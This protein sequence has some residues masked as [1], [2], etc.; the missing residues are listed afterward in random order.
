MKIR[1]LGQNLKVSA[2][3]Y[4][5]MGLSFGYGPPTEKVQAIAVIRAAVEHGVTL[6]RSRIMRPAQLRAANT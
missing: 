6:P 2:I 3:G 1:T 5:A 4:G